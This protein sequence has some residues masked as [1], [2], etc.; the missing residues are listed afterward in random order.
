MIIKV[1]AVVGV[2]SL[3][4]GDAAAKSFKDNFTRLNTR[5]WTV[6][7]WQG[8]GQT[9]KHEGVF[10]ADN[11]SIVKG[12]LR[13][14]LDQVKLANG[15]IQSVGSE[16]VSNREFGYGVYEF[17][18]KASSTAELPDQSGS[19]ISGSVSAA[20]VYAPN[21][22]T[23]IDVEFEG[24]ERK[25]LT[26]FITWVDENRRNQHS[27]K[28]LPGPEP[29]ERFYTYKII[30]QPGMVTFY[31]DG[32]LISQHR[33]IVPKNPGKMIFNHWGTHL[34]WWGGWATENTPRY[35]FVDYF[36]FT[37]IKVD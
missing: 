4:A 9:N 17:R 34:N 22:T 6:S 20:F 14:K 28:R 15:K 26:H 13:L 35:M 23:E 1:A 21:A 29:Y 18:M 3:L 33:S 31:R 19:A 5:N 10:D 24:N 11:V 32:E 16:I 8:P 7:S 2:L 30:W 27:K 37:P 36:K 25:G 12:H